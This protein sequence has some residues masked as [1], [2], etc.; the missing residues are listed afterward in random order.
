[1]ESILRACERWNA[2]RLIITKNLQPNKFHDMF[3]K[4]FLP[5]IILNY[6]RCLYLDTDIIINSKSPNPFEIYRDKNKVYVI[7]D[8]QQPFLSDDEKNNF[9]DSTLCMPWFNTCKKALNINLNPNTYKSNFFNAGIF[10]FSPKIHHYIFL[11]IQKSLSKIPDS[12]KNI[13]QVEQSLLNYSFMYY[14]KDNLIYIPKE[15][16]YIDPP[17]SSNIMEGFIYHFTGWYY[18]EY[19]RKINNFT[20]WK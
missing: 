1:M 19:K 12:H 16:N 9:K 15:W 20:L 18:E 10:L 14:L 8:M 3:T 5:N 2:D 7:K 4:L 17:L 13:H 11:K 6:D